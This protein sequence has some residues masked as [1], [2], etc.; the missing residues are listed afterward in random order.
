MEE[1]AATPAAARDHLE[2]AASD[3][4]A[5]AAED[6]G[7]G[8]SISEETA[9]EIAEIEGAV[10]AIGVGRTERGIGEA[11]TAGGGTAGVTLGAEALKAATV[12]RRT[13]IHPTPRSF[14]VSRCA[15]V[16]SNRRT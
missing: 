4:T 5:G 13:G 1:G 14:N 6:P 2:S 8:E 9:G 10:P 3:R 11:T 7:R 12:S 16:A 15:I